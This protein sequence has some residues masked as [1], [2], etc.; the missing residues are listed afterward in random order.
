MVIVLQVVALPLLILCARQ[1]RDGVVLQPGDVVMAFA[2]VV[3]GARMGANG[4][5]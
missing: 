2:V 4:G 1:V 5:A 3:P